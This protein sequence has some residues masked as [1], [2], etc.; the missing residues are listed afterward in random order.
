MKS[1]APRLNP[2]T[3]RQ[4]RFCHE[5]VHWA[6]G[7]VAAREAGYSAA[8]SRKQG[9]ALLKTERIRARIG[10]IQAQ[11]ARDA[12]A[13]TE[14]LIGKLEVVYRRAI[15]DHHFYAAARAVELQA[16]L[17]RMAAADASPRLFPA[18]VLQEARTG[19]SPDRD[20][21]QEARSGA[22]TTGI[23]QECADAKASNCNGPGK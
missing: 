21:K 20:K 22:A 17:A 14:A 5:F 18:P 1:L 15:G 11:L 4:E 7:A 10:E 9:S 19:F 6:Q 23:K 13:G 12:G 3:P 8:S 16:R 2:L